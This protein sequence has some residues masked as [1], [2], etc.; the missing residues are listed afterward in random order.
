MS[1]MLNQIFIIRVFSIIFTRDIFP[2]ICLKNKLT[3]TCAPKYELFIWRYKY[4][5]RWPAVNK[6][7]ETN[8]FWSSSNL[9]QR[10]FRWPAVVCWSPSP[11]SSFYIKEDRRSNWLT[12]TNIES[13]VLGF[14][15]LTVYCMPLLN[16]FWYKGT[17]V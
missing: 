12:K 11:W 9:S 17:T 14:S 4:I 15:L 10:N 7:Y 5:L 1:M 3:L 6:R 13:W 8:L 2:K 16:K